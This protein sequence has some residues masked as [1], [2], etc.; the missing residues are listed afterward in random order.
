MI[1]DT[2][3]ILDGRIVN[4]GIEFTCLHDKRYDPQLVLSEA[5]SRL[6]EHF[7]NPG[8][9]G[10]SVSLSEIYSILNKMV[11]GVSSTRKELR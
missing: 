3:D 10:Q 5:K 9:F 2:I 8:D 7:Q 11:K 1:H 6:A 4:F